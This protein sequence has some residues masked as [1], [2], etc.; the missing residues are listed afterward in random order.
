MFLR[1]QVAIIPH[2]ALGKLRTD[3]G[4]GVQIPTRRGW[5]GGY[6]RGFG[7]AQLQGGGGGGQAQQVLRQFKDMLLGVAQNQSIFR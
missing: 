5:G 3:S 4:H 7:Y 2:K 1:E 6:K